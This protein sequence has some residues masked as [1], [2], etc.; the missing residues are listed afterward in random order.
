MPENRGGE[1]GGD[2]RFLFLIGGKLNN[3]VI[4]GDILVNFLRILNTKSTYFSKKM[5]NGKLFFH[6]FQ[7]IAHLLC[8]YGDFWGWWVCISVTRKTQTSH[9]RERNSLMISV[10]NTNWIH[11]VGYNSIT[12]RSVTNG[13]KVDSSS[14]EIGKVLKNRFF[15]RIKQ[16]SHLSIRH[17]HGWLFSR[18][19]LT[20]FSC[21]EVSVMCLMLSL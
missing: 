1:G 16:F 9:Y 8:Q 18:M 2:K 11:P 17:P 7:H 3:L 14:S 19:L 10:I 4:Y 6:R 20:S 15:D 21:Y 13:A 5:K 12:K